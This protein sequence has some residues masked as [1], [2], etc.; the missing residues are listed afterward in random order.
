M[1]IVH[2]T[3]FSEEAAAAEREA[4]RLARRLGA[5]LLILHVSVEAPLYGESPFGMAD[6]TRVFEGQ[7]RWAEARLTE[8]AEAL[9]RDGVPTRWRRRVGGVHETVCDTAREEA[10]E[11]IVIGTHG[12]GGLDRFMLGS[13]AERVVRSA[14]CPVVT[15]R[16]K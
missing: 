2:P 6:V 8:R 1:I 14:P 15:V 5:E 9:T 7:A 11:Y 16:P 13:I 10:A 4:V 12:R 3:D